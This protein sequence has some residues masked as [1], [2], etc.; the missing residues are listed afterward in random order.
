MSDLGPDFEPAAV[1]L[2]NLPYGVH[3]VDRHGILRWLNDRELRD[4][5]YKPEQVLGQPIANLHV[6][7]P[8]IE[9]IFALLEGGAEILSYPARLR[10]ADGTIVYALINSNVCRDENGGFR[11]TRCLTR[12][13]SQVVYEF[14]LSMLEGDSCRAKNA[15]RR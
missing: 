11:H 8:V 5:G 13:V 3:L 1:L 2:Q 12:L 9:K 10:A 14:H 15:S 7:P 4:L 6:D